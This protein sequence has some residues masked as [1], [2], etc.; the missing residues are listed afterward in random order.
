M[1]RIDEHLLAAVQPVQEQHPLAP[2]HSETPGLIVDRL[3]ILSLKIYHTG[4]E[5]AAGHSHRGAPHPQPG[6]LGRAGGATDR[7]GE[8]PGR[9]LATD[10]RGGNDGLSCTGR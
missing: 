2:L 5:G 7:P 8:L 10:R 4:E 1:E 9:A 3:S 6:P